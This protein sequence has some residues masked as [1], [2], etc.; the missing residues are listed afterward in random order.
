MKNHHNG[1]P[2]F[3]TPG[4]SGNEKMLN[5]GLSYATYHRHYEQPSNCRHRTYQWTNCYKR[6]TH[7]TSATVSAIPEMPTEL[8]AAVTSGDLPAVNALFKRRD[9]HGGNGDKKKKQQQ[10]WYH[11]KFGDDHPAHDIVQ[12]CPKVA[13]QSRETPRAVDKR[14]RIWL[15][16]TNNKTTPLHGRLPH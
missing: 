15:A 5:D 8:A 7:C 2:N 13:Q 3:G 14:R 1:W 12:T 10:C 4:A 6:Q 9:G 16:Q 11:V